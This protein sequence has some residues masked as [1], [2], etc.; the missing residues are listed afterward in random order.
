MIKVL[1]TPPASEPLTVGELKLF[2]RTDADTTEEDAFLGRL[3]TMARLQ[4]EADTRGR[5]L[6]AQTWEYGWMYWPRHPYLQL[7]RGPIQSVVSFG[8]T[9][10]DGAHTFA[11]DEYLLDPLDDRQLPLVRMQAPW[12][13]ALLR[14]PTG[15]R[16]R[17]TLGD[18]A[19][20]EPLL[21][22][23]R[24]LIAYWYDNREA[25]LAST[26]YKAEVAVLPLQY[27]TLIRP[28]TYGP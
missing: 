18:T 22:A 1:I 5:V 16:L 11:A 6:L 7:P 2:L 13:T 24:A 23:M 4:V 12:P 25:A 20:P 26:A 14:Y 15:L 19:P 21:G 17:V 8:Y 28:Y 10:D 9:D 27:Q 3:L